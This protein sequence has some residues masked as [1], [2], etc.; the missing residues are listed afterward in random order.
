MKPTIL[1]NASGDAPELWFGEEFGPDDYGLISANAVRD[2][3]GQIG[4]SKKLNVHFNTPG[5]DVIEA[6]GIYNLLKNC[7]MKITSLVDVALSCGS[8]VAQ[9]GDTVRM[10]QNGLMMIHDPE[11]CAYGNAAQLRQQAT[12][13]DQVK[14]AILSS[15]SSRNLKMSADQLSQAMSQET[16]YTAEQAMDC[17][18]IDAIDPN[19]S[20]TM[21]AGLK[22][23][24]NA[25]SWAAELERTNREDWRRAMNERRL[26]LNELDLLT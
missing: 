7:G 12:T 14:A 26:K 20:I 16:W 9:V 18:L 13:L 25:P 1:R 4:G 24:K 22:R 10:S 15:Y 5:G 3:L 19:K 21:S 17:G 2:A 6:I 11:T 8:W 23:F